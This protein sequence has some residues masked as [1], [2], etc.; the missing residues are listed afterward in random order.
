[1]SAIATRV[2][3]AHLPSPLADK[4]DLVAEQLERSRG[5]IVKQALT[6]WLSQ[7]EERERLT[8]EAMADVDAGRLIEH[9]DMQAWAQSLSS[10]QALPLPSA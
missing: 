3:T 10:G 5:W 9:A 8:R 4:I 2:I 7:E 1:M 6:L